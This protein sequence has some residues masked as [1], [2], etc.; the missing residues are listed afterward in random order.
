MIIK[1]WWYKC[2]KYNNLD[3]NYDN[4]IIYLKMIVMIIE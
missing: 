4:M 2:W 1:I 3:N